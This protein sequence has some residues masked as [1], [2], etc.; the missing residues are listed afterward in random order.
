MNGYYSAPVDAGFR[1]LESITDGAFLEAVVHGVGAPILIL[2]ADG[3]VLA[4]NRKAA[5]ILG[6]GGNDLVGRILR[7]SFTVP[8]PVLD[9]RARVGRGRVGDSEGREFWEC[10]FVVGEMGME[11]VYLEVAILEVGGA[12]GAVA[13]ADRGLLSTIA[14]EVRGPMASIRGFVEAVAKE[15]DMDASVRADFLGIALGEVD[16]LGKLVDGLV[17]WARLQTGGPGPVEAQSVSVVV[18]RVMARLRR[19]IE[20]AG[21]SWVVDMAD[22]LPLIEFESRQLEVLLF[23][24]AANALRYTP[25]GGRVRLHAFAS[26]SMMAILVEDSGPGVAADEREKIFELCYRG[27]AGR[28]AG[29]GAGIGLSVAVGILR[30]HHGRID[31][32]SKQDGGS[33]FVVAIPLKQARS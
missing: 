13:G 1:R 8:V 27:R 3:R 20:A 32:I 17:E 24:L 22:G 16:R 6:A 33:T 5:S 14:H 4:G 18:D 25:R 21:Q 11:G 19:D 29:Q 12:V 23:E 2:D 15:P 28:S 9:G 10:L 30:R 26:G 31:V 7:R